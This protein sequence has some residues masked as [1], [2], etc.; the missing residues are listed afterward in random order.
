M[1]DNNPRDPKLDLGVQLGG[2]FKNLGDLVNA[3][4]SAVEQ[5]E[6][7]VKREGGSVERSGE[8]SF[9]PE[10]KQMRGVYGFSIRTAGGIPRVQPFGNIRPTAQGPEVAEVREPLVDLFD[11]GDEMV[12]IAEVPGVDAADVQVELHGDIL[13]LETQGSR[14]YAKEVLLPAPGDP[15]TLHSNYRNGILEVRVRKQPPHSAS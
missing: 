10:G 15:A 1:S 8:V 7:V 2:L 14:R 4:S 12:L 6:Q 9:G 11:E 13:A 3:I 5:A